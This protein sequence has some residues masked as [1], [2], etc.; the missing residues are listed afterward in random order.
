MAFIA[1]QH[2]I[3][4]Y[5][6]ASN[7]NDTE[8]QGYPTAHGVT[9]LSMFVFGGQKTR[10]SLMY[11]CGICPIFCHCLNSEWRVT[12]GLGTKFM[13]MFKWIKDHVFLAIDWIFPRRMADY[14]RIVRMAAMNPCS[15][16][17][18]IPE[19]FAAA[20]AGESGPRLGADLR[21]GLD[22][23]SLQ[24]VET[25]L[26]RVA[27]FPTRTDGYVFLVYANTVLT[28][29]ERRDLARW[30]DVRRECQRQFRYPRKLFSTESFFYH[31]GMD[32]L[33]Q[34]CPDYVSGKDFIDLGAF[35]GDSTLILNQYHPRKIYAFDASPANARRFWRTMRLNGV[36]PAR[37]ELVLAGVSDAPGKMC[38]QDTGQGDTALTVTGGTEIE[39]TTVD[40][41]TAGKNLSIGVIKMDIEGMGLKAVHGMAQTLRTHRPVLLLAV[42]HNADEFFGIK[43]FI[44]SLNLNYAFMLRKL[45]PSHLFTETTLLVY[46][47][48]L[49]GKKT[50]ADV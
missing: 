18:G 16:H 36:D 12:N 29:Q 43:P 1:Q 23:E 35:I 47:A 10:N 6:V 17:V 24:L 38:F 37:V 19:S 20:L 22:A 48:E 49:A 15:I 4:H 42:Y 32:D 33:P 25:L 2:L 27:F 8:I 31:H 41:F 46:P 45:S 14:L 28:E 50:D 13:Q 11:A 3:R 5:P 39:I 44:E 30:P 26:A 21:R 40:A 7:E 9:M 34:A